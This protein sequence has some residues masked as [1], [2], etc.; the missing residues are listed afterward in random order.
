MFS[1]DLIFFFNKGRGN[2]SQGKPEHKNKH[3]F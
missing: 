1:Y 2:K 3:F